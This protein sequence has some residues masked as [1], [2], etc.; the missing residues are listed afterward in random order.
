M[1]KLDT[2]VHEAYGYFLDALDM[3]HIE[4]IVDEQH[5]GNQIDRYANDKIRLQFVDD[6]GEEFIQLFSTR[7][8]GDLFSLRYLTAMLKPDLQHNSNLAS[9]KA[10]VDLRDYVYGLFESRYYMCYRRAYRLYESC[11]NEAHFD[12]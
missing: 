11:R 7:Y 1:K 12:G 6:R 10:L 3:K 5:F 2:Y 4:Y 9:V 8:P